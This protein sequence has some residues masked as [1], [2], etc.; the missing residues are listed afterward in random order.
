MDA[1]KHCDRF[2]LRAPV[3]WYSRIQIC[4]K[5]GRRYM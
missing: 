3:W 1:M 2:L 5:N 4:R